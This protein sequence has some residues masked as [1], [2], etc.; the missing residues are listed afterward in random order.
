MELI[1]RYLYAV[2]KHLPQKIK[3][4]IED[5]LRSS[6]LDAIDAKSGGNPSQEDIISVLKD[7]GHPRKIAQNYTTGG[8]YIIGPHLYD[9]YMLILKLVVGFGVLGVI[10]GFIID[11]AQGSGMFNP[12]TLLTNVLSTITGAVGTVTI[13]FAIA[14]RLNPDLD[15]QLRH[16]EKNWNPNDLPT[17][18]KSYEKVKLSETIT[19]MLF[20]VLFFLFIN[21]YTHIFGIYLKVY[22][23]TIQF[24]S[25]VDLQNFEKYI[26][27]LNI[28][29]GLSFIKQLL[30]IRDGQFK[31]YTFLIEILGSL[32]G[33]LVAAFM[34]ASPAIINLSQLNLFI[35]NPESLAKLKDILN[36]IYRGILVGC[37]I[38]GLVDMIKY[39][40]RLVKYMMGKRL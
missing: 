20:T 24:I 15:I 3:K 8:S 23:G 22:D 25:L 37:C 27:L 40:F 38:F 28:L 33:V 10:I 16:Y 5:E 4:D 35:T 2:C 26:P 1:D 18:P 19:E 36:L 7:F 11:A 14:E 13:V 21:F 6:I 29:L 12:I 34:L 32:G 17:I 31:P 30:L 9:L 39:I